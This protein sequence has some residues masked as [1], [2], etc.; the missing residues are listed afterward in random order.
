MF[1][2][3]IDPRRKIKQ[4]CMQVTNANQLKGLRLQAEDG[5]FI[6]D[7][8]WDLKHGFKRW[9]THQIPDGKAIVGIKAVTNGHSG[10]I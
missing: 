9:V 4:V 3:T 1:Q 5:S 6:L 8:T 7:V 10:E 2:R